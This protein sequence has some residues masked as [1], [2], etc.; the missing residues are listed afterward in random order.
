MNNLGL[1]CE[2]LHKNESDYVEQN[3]KHDYIYSNEDSQD[4]IQEEFKEEIQD[5][6]LK[7]TIGTLDSPFAFLT[8]RIS[9]IFKRG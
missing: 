1:S 4:E 7:R 8:V 2:E 3:M 9:K 6:R 5:S